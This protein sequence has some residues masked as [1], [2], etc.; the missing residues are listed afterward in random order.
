MLINDKSSDAAETRSRRTTVSGNGA[1]LEIFPVVWPD[2]SEPEPP[3]LQHPVAVR[4]DSLTARPLNLHIL[5]ATLQVNASGLGGGSLRVAIEPVVA[6]EAQ[7]SILRTQ[8]LEDGRP[9]AGCAVRV[10][11]ASLAPEIVTLELRIEGARVGMVP[12]A[13][14]IWASVHSQLRSSIDEAI[15]VRRLTPRM[16]LPQDDSIM[17]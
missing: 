17:G 10:P 15:T 6:G 4:I 3:T 14:H 2:F 13:L 1:D 5:L 11:L 8:P 12:P 16:L 9:D 7:L